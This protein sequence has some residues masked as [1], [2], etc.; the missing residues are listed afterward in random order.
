MLDTMLQKIDEVQKLINNYR[1]F[2]DNCLLKEI[3]NFYRIG[4]VYSSN[5][6]EGYS[7]TLSE[8]KIL[9]ENGLTAGGKP[10][11]DAFAV[12]GLSNAYDYMFSLL[13]KASLEEK[14]LFIMHSMLDGSL[15]NQATSGKYRTH[16]VLIS[17]SSYGVSDVNEIPDH[18]DKLFQ[19]L[20]KNK[21]ALHP[22]ELA[23][24]FHKNFVFIHPFGDGNGRIA[25]LG[26]NVLLIQRGYLPV[27]IPPI[28]RQN[29]VDALELAHKN[30][31]KFIELIAQ[32][33]LETQ[34]DFL[35]LV[36]GLNR[37]DTSCRVWGEESFRKTKNE[38]GIEQDLNIEQFDNSSIKRAGH[39]RA[40]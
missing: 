31:A 10:L 11:R 37:R 24:K 35:R 26:M 23:A 34:K 39:K 20:D 27:A 28:L 4:S 7:Y 32:N 29:Y 19:F 13:H 3:K 33:E 38:T 18:M 17:G 40:R 15:D 9:I 22:I 6:I 36:K 8:T 21:E 16:P 25:R 12:T 14:D 30:D 2:E 5:A 1:P